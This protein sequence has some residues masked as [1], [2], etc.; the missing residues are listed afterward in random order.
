MKKLLT[1]LRKTPPRQIFK[2]I[3]FRLNGRVVTLKPRGVSRGNVLLSYITTPFTLLAE[4]Q[5]NGH[6]NYWETRDM[7]RAFLERGY[8]VDVIDKND[9]A[10][11][12]KKRYAC[13]IDIESNLARLAPLL[14]PDCIKIFHNAAEMAR[15]A[16]LKA[17][18][19]AALLPRRVTPPY[20]V[21][22]A[23]LLSSLCGPF[24]EST[25]AFLKKPIYHIPL[26]TTH[27]YP[28]PEKNYDSARKRFIW[29]GG[30]GA[31]HKG[32]D[33]VLEAFA[34][35]PEYT[36]LVCGKFGEQDFN[37]AYKKELTGMPHIQSIGYIDPGSEQFK[38]I[39][40]DSLAIVFPSCSEGCASSVVVTM[41]AGIIPIVSR[42]SG[43]ETRDFGITLVENTITAIQDAVRMLASEPKEKLAER[44]IAAWS[45]ARA[46]HTRERFAE[47]YRAFLSI[48]E[49]KHI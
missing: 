18:R 38:E 44:S 35:M 37:D 40:R 1:M 23:D 39:A 19:G 5:F 41:H 46:N 17:R 45:Y 33:L 29:F 13:F 49:E 6:T 28:K 8:S 9:T 2:R 47:A 36:L 25:Y 21:A 4:D 48:L 15:L 22:P 3:L 34:A 20:D 14:N 43:I 32:L 10:F 30:A 16:D 42:E 11:I 31:V 27:T 26:S 12:P 24:P 7:A